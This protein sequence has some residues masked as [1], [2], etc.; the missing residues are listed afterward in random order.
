MALGKLSKELRTL[1]WSHTYQNLRTS[2]KRDFFD[3]FL[4]NPWHKIL[5]DHHVFLLHKPADEF[6]SNFKTITEIIKSLFIQADFNKVL[7][8]LEFVLRHN[9]VPHGFLDI[10]EETLREHKCA[11]IVMLIED[12]PT[13]I[14]VVLP[15]Q[16]ESVKR[17]F[18]VLESGPFRGARSHLRTS[19][20]CINKGDLAGSVRESIHAVESIARCLDPNG[21]TSLKSALQALS[22]KGVTLHPALK[23]G[24]VKFY[25]YTSNQDGIRHALLEKETSDVDEE[26]AIFMFGA[27]LSFSAYLVSK[28]RKAGLSLGENQ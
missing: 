25:G 3:E 17:D 10:V 21:S 8:F 13:I 1:L 5:Y 22:N 6:G 14:P 12:I 19:A 27:C 16:T 9:S 7:D 2:V 24:I 20:V 28:A 11:Y 26:E 15:E 18:Q 23:Q 4:V